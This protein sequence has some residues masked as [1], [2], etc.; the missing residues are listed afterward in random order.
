MNEAFDPASDPVL[1]EE[2]S[3]TR[4]DEPRRPLAETARPKRREYRTLFS[5]LRNR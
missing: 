5:T 1:P 2:T 3:V 4:R